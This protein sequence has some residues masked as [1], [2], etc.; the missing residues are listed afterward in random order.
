DEQRFRVGPFGA[1]RL[2]GEMQR[3]RKKAEPDAG[4]V[5]VDRVDGGKEC[6]D[7]PGPGHGIEADERREKPVHGRTFYCFVNTCL[8]L[9]GVPPVSVRV[10]ST[11]ILPRASTAR[12]LSK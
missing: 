8:T 3:Q 2:E 6:V 1:R 10:V 9:T 11:T 5:A 12:A 4:G 7:R